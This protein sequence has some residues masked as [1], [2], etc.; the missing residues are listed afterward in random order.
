MAAPRARSGGTA[1]ALGMVIAGAAA[2]P[3][4]IIN[5]TLR[6]F[7]SGTAIPKPECPTCCNPDVP[8][9]GLC[10]SPG[11]ERGYHGPVRH[12]LQS[13]DLSTARRRLPHASGHRRKLRS[14]VRAS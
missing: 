6:R 7:I 2:R 13:P 4:P 10:R 8:C 9:L 14:W 3:T 5:I 12:C 1:L 11:A